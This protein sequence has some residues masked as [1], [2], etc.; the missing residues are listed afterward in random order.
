LV[1]V[2]VTESFV[3]AC[4]SATTDASSAGSVRTFRSV[5]AYLLSV[6][7]SFTIGLIVSEAELLGFGATTFLMGARAM[8]RLIS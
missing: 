4:T 5:V 3:P 8:W 1:I 2:S 6:T 7:L